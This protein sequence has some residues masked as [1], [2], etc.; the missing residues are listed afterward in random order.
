MWLVAVGVAVVVHGTVLGAAGSLG[1][2]RESFAAVTQ[3]PNI[4]DTAELETTCSGDVILATTARAAMCLAPWSEDRPECADGVQMMMWMDLSACRGS[5]DDAAPVAMAMLQPKQLEKL[6]PIDPEPLLEEL[7]PEDMPKPPPPQPQLQPQPPPPPPPPPAPKPRRPQQVVEVAKPTEEQAPDNARLLAEYNT[8]VEKQKVARGSRDEPM[9]AK[10]KP[11]ELT[12]KQK[13]KDEVS[14]KKL[15]DDRGKNARA[16]KVP[17][18]LAMR[19]PGAPNPAKAPQQEMHRGE[20][21]ERQ[22]I[23]ADGFIPRRGDGAIE[24]LR[25]DPGELTRGQGGAGG[26]SPQIPNLRPTKEQLERIVGG[27]S[28]DHLDDV[29]N[30]DET[31][32]NAR[33]WVYASFFNRLKRQVAQNWNPQDVWRRID[34]DGTHN[35]FKTRVTEVRVTLSR[36]G[37]L[38]KIVVTNPSGVTELDNEAVSAFHKA[39]PFPNP[40]DGLVSKDGSIS[41][42]FSFYF[43]IGE[44]HTAWRVLR[45]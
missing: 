36:R 34:P 28:V 38:V 29:E 26:G 41:F 27:G 30:G 40:P 20:R 18:T 17:G 4:D 9:V 15:E 25:R 11:E 31:A 6:K 35:G 3:Q 32:L 42:A 16:P 10:S 8:R 22:P 12:A 19:P 23:V 13:P 44:P 1:W 24:Q 7:K 5:P 2:V 45:Q 21:G 33:R 43:E 37:K 39:Q 14:I